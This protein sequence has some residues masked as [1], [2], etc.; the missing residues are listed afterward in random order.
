MKS[1]NSEG[2][3]DLPPSSTWTTEQALAAAQKMDLLNVLIVGYG[4]DG[5][6]VIRSS[7]MSKQQALWLAKQAERYSLDG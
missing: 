7:R 4:R 1:P 2:P 6:L 3:A 5:K